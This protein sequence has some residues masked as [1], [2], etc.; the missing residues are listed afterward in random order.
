MRGRGDPGAG[1]REAGGAKAGDGAIIVPAYARTA[2]IYDVM[3]GRYAFDMW[4]DNFEKLSHAYDIDISMVADVA[5][6]TGMV[7]RYL[8]ER[9]AEVL[10]CDISRQM[11]KAAL[12]AM[13]CCENGKQIR[14]F[15]Q[16]MRCLSL[17]RR[18][19]LLI[20]STDAL[21]HLLKEEDISKALSAFKAALAKGGHALFDMN[22]LWQLREGCDS[23]TWCFEVEGKAMRWTSRWDERSATA[24]LFMEYEGPGGQKEVEVHRERGYEGDFIA[25]EALRS[26]F[27][28]IDVYDAK[29]LENPSMHTRR[30]QFVAWA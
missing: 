7:S 3:V 30:L 9:G 20:C 11:L 4:K 21:N 6:G 17:P 27:S 13:V 25:R 28:G 15:R 26:G 18:V 19:P 14:F 29:G 23:E 22:T 12:K 1:E 24:T 2:E 10:A 5:C 16:D 8:A